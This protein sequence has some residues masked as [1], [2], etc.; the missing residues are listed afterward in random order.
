MLA[1]LQALEQGAVAAGQPA[2]A[3]TGQPVRLGG[4][5]ERD[6]RLGE[7]GGLGERAC[8]VDLDAA[9]DLIA[10]Q[11][12][13][14][15]VAQRHQL[16][17]GRLVGNV[18]CRVVREVDRDEPRR[19]AQ[20]GAQLVEV[21]RPAVL[22]M[23][24][25]GAHVR[26]C[27][28]RDRLHR[29]VARHRDDGVVAGADELLHG[30][31]ERLLGAGEGEHVRGVH[32]LVG[33][34]DGLSQPRRAPRLYVGQWQLHQT[35]TVGVRAQ[36]QKLFHRDALGVGGGEVVADLELPFAE[37]LLETER[38]QRLHERASL[39]KA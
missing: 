21:Q 11:T 12:D 32:A 35:L 10:E 38:A 14:A 15:L 24:R 34:G 3:Q 33:A 25:P 22:A 17:E 27:R 9:I 31:E 19:R 26:A 16:A 13:S 18:P 6:G 39:S 1:L 30:P 37:V 8:R 5:V 28:Q 4:D 20:Q 2:D 23:R 29:L 36:C 7:V